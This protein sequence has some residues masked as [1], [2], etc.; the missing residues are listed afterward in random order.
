MPTLVLSRIS[1]EARHGATPA[2]RRSL[3]RFEVDIEID[4]PLEKAQSTDRLSDTIDYRQVAEI[5]V[6]IGTGKTHHLLEALARDM[7]NAL[8]VRLPGVALRL[9]LR[10]L[11]PPDCPGQPAWAAVRMA[12]PDGERKG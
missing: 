6:G 4:A 10:K 12:Y 8:V 11:N 5:I 3:R 7:I 1:F 2:E 9:E